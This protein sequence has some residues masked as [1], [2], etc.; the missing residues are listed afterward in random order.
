MTQLSEYISIFN[1]ALEYRKYHVM[2]NVI[3]ELENQ[4]Q[5]SEYEAEKDLIQSVLNSMT[6]KIFKEKYDV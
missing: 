3:I 2:W 5:S 4:L 6:S 1:T